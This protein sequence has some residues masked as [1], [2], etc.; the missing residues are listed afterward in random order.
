LWPIGQKLRHYAGS[1]WEVVEAR[2]FRGTS[3]QWMSDYR[4]RC[5]SD[6]MESFGGEKV[7]RTDS[8]HGEYLHRHGWTAVDA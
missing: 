4:M 6:P 1:V 7:G 5:L 8:F 2:P 3:H